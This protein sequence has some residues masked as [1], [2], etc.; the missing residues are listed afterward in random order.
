VS[1][2]P[3]SPKL[4]KGGLVV[5]DPDTAQALRIISAQYNAGTLSP[6]LQGQE[7]GGASAAPA[8]AQAEPRA[9]LIAR[10]L[11]RLLKPTGS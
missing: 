10:S 2:F 3:G 6:T 5:I 9:T 8:C 11:N 4:I 7:A 1:S